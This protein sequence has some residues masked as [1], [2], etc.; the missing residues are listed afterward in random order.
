VQRGHQRVIRQLHIGLGATAEFAHLT[1]IQGNLT[2]G[3][4][5]GFELD[6]DRNRTTPEQVLA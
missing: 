5:T 2:A 1:R 6:D 3:F 4:R